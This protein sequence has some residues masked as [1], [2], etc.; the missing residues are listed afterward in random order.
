MAVSTTTSWH[1]QVLSGVGSQW[2]GVLVSDLVGAGGVAEAVALETHHLVGGA[3]QGGDGGHHG[4]GARRQRQQRLIGRR[5]TVWGC[6]G[7]LWDGAGRS[8][9]PC[10]GEGQKGR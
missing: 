9:W 3:L 6:S 10:G 5:A 2:E 8:H 1:Y 7:A 4:S